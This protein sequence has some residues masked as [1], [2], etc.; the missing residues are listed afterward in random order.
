MPII[1][2]AM[3]HTIQQSNLAALAKAKRNLHKLIEADRPVKVSA[4]VR[5]I[6]KARDAANGALIACRL[7]GESEALVSEAML[8]HGLADEASKVR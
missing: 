4:R 3:K 2:V 6:L 1:V 5:T 7:F 8:V